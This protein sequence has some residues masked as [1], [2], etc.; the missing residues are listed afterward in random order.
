MPAY[1]AP[2]CYAS[3]R[4]AIT[5]KEVLQEMSAR[6]HPFVVSLR[7]AFQDARHLFLLLDFV[8]GGD[9]FNLL[10]SKEKLPEDWVRR[11]ACRAVPPLECA[12]ARRCQVRA[13]PPRAPHPPAWLSP[14]APQRCR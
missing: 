12:R 7:Y 6:P 11:A 4:Q 10:E 14:L 3:A 9:L 13:W 8:G 1:R 2:P 5:E